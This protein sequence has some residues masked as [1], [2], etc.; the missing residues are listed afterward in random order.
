M[1]RSSFPQDKPRVYLED[2]ASEGLKIQVNY[3]FGP[4]DWWKYVEFNHDFN[5][6]LLR[7][8]KEEGISLMTPAQKI[9]INGDPESP[10]VMRNLFPERGPRV[11]T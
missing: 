6:E 2:I 8:F 10:P 11:G 1:R 4:T 7:R 5:L 9:F 3:W